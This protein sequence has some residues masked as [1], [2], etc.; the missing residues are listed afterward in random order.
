MKLE[1]K[2]NNTPSNLLFPKVKAC[3]HIHSG[4][5]GSGFLVPTKQLF[6]QRRFFLGIDS[7]MLGA[8]RKPVSFPKF[9]INNN[10]KICYLSFFFFFL[11]SGTK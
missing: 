11:C 5:D 8:P 2:S 4:P 7:N 6:S 10:F 1:H 3:E 9:A